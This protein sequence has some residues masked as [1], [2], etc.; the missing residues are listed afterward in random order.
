MQFGGGGTPPVGVLFDGAF[1]RIGDLLALAVLYGLQSKSE[2]R[3][4]SISVNRPDLT[5][6]QF[7]DAV[8]TYYSGGGFF[9][10]G[11][12]VGAA[13]GTQRPLPVYAKL[14]AKKDEEDEPVFKTSLSS[15]IDTADPAIL[16][17][18]AL[19]ASQP[20]NSIV[21]AS[22]S[23]A[24]VAR[25]LALRGSNLLIEDTV[26][27]LVIADPKNVDPK[28]GDAQR[29]FAEW[30]MP[31]YLC[32]AEI[33]DAIRYPAASIESDFKGPKPNP[34]AD[35]YRA[36]GEMPYDAPTAAADAGLFAVRT[37]AGLFKLSDPGTFRVSASGAIELE[38][39]ATGKHRRLILDETQKDNVV[40]ALTQLAST[41]PRPGGG[42]RGARPEAAPANANG[43]QPAVVKKK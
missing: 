34:F 20:H 13:M 22:G 4:A 10:G 27:H 21:V 15:L 14:L 30:P 7:C 40:K 12:P 18:N 32:G 5:A 6:A 24:S 3:V 31:I 26:R 9:G 33:G 19:T 17:R 39:S 28:N 42:R 35:A 23:L 38:P 41:P 25:L 1:E 8:K 43:N 16:M 37:K 11:L 36:F 29:V 2:A